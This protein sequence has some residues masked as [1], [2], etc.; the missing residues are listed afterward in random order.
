MHIL[1]AILSF[2]SFIAFLIIRANYTVEAMKNLSGEAAGIRGAIRR[3]FFKRKANTHPLELI[4][5]PREAVLALMVAI[6][7]DKGDLSAEQIADLEY[8]AEYRLN[9]NNPADMVKLARWHV[10]DHVE[11]GA[12]LYRLSKGLTRNCT[13]EQRADIINLVESAAKG[14]RSNKK[15]LTELQA[16]TVQQLKYRFGD[17]SQETHLH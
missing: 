17:V 7:K 12:V 11:S 4:E 16:H 10:R 6:M 8:W 3:F 15:E 1:I 2:L 14:R 13:G 5:D 9:Y